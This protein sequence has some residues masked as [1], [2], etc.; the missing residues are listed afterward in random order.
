MAWFEVVIN[1]PTMDCGRV[2]SGSLVIKSQLK[3]NKTIKY[4]VKTGPRIK[5]WSSCSLGFHD[6]EM[7]NAK[8]GLISSWWGT[9]TGARW[10]KWR[11]LFV[12]SVHRFIKISYTS[13]LPEE[14]GVQLL[15]AARYVIWHGAETWTLTKQAQN[16]LTAAQNKMARCMLNITYNDRNTNIWVR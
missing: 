2:W 13:R 3:V 6:Y 8:V 7:G 1:S 4:F 5:A 15:C 16:K 9:L 14:T 11:L 10:G 12:K